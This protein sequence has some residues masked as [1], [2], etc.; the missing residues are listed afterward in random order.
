VPE[1]V[2]RA[3]GLLA[4]IPRQRGRCG[5][6]ADS[7]P[8]EV[9]AESLAAAREWFGMIRRSACGR[10][11]AWFLLALAG[12]AL[13]E[14][15]AGAELPEA[16]N[17]LVARSM[18]DRDF[19]G[20]VILIVHSGRE[21]VVGLILNRTTTVPLVHLFPEMRSTA[22]GNDPVYLGGMIALGVR[23]L[24]RSSSSKEGAQR[25]LNDVWVLSD[26]AAVEK[27]ARRGQRTEAFRVYAGYAGWSQS[28]LRK[29]LLLGH[30]RVLPG[31]ASAVFD[32]HPE[33]L[34]RRLSTRR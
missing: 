4:S 18:P 15:A 14:T 32:P 26:G 16:G 22:A 13:S 6:K 9:A 31:D 21:G 34:W 3:A 7:Y 24:L 27:A 33:T 23:A 10:A 20:T 2:Q 1:V 17:M 11:A 25:L 29:E 19:A 8:G 5:L 30:W 12:L 28:Q